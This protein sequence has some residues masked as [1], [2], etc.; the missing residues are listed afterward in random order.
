M[1]LEAENLFDHVLELKL[2][3]AIASNRLIRL[4]N[5]IVNDKLASMHQQLMTV[6]N[7]SEQ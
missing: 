2:Q 5:P 3:T 6:I 4:D 1:L 7:E